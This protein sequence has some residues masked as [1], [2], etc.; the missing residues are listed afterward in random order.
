MHPIELLLIA[1]GLSM[2]AFAVSVAAGISIADVRFR[3]ALIVGLYF[4]FFQAA[5]PVAGY[6]VA[7]LFAD[8]VTSVDHWIAFGLLVFLGLRMVVNSLRQ[9]GCADRSCPDGLCADRDCPGGS[10]PEPRQISLSP[11]QMLPYAVATSIDALAVGVSFAFL[12]VAILPA[13]LAIGITT[14]LLSMVGVRLGNAIGKRFQSR[15][16]LVGGVVLVLIGIKVLLEHL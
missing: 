8:L 9:E 1:V 15:A 11:A 4:G 14:L 2:D 7:S 12:D 13:A 16:E 10:K 6:L 3:H 5:M